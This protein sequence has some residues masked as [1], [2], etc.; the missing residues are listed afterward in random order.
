MSASK[1]QPLAGLRV[2]DL[3]RALAGPYA[4]LL[5]AGLGAE[6][7][8]VEDPRHGD[9][10]REN[11]PYVGRDGVV[12]QKAHD[13]DVS[14]SHLSR[15]RGKWGVSLNFKKPGALDVFADLIRDADILV[16][17]FASGTADR[18]G[19]GYA[20]AKAINPRLIYCSL[21]GFGQGVDEGAKAMDVIVQA[22]SGAMYASGGPGEPPVRM[23]IPIADMLAPVFG[24]IGILSALEQRHRTGEG[25][26]VDVS[27][28]G[29]LTSFVGIENW[30]AMRL[31]GLPRRTGLTVHRLSPFGIFK[32]R[33]G[34]IAIVAA[35]DPLTIGL[36]KAMRA[37]DMLADAR[38]A[39]R[40]A[41]VANAILLEE[42]I[43]EWTSELSVAEAVAALEAEGVPVAPVRYPEDALA[44]PRV[45][46]REETMQIVHPRY[47]TD[48]ELRTV[49]VPI[50]FSDAQTGFAD[51]LPVA[52]G[53]HNDAVYRDLLGYP[54][55]RIAALREAG[56]I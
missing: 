18:L 32:C 23:G 20:A 5:L 43:T 3:T 35:H 8:K 24:V 21:S 47:E 10:A 26:Q 25:Q 54:P 50:R 52:I 28:L 12:V 34:H 27:M 45:V 11:S 6:V 37:D 17:N 1:E 15:A 39:T 53:E 42:R 55:E 13:D 49:G 36:F 33:D 31:A 14:I 48:A 46:A 7:I 9:L 56:A 22:L 16:E 38:Y 2:I 41:R 19:I 40:D 51:R 29:A 44:D 4:T 30:R